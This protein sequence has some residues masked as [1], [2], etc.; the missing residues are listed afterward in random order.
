MFQP[1]QAAKAPSDDDEH[2]RDEVAVLLPERFQLVELFLLFEVEMSGH[3][4]V[5]EAPRGIAGVAGKRRI[6]R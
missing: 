2:P 3:G 1:F 6:M 5:P 4:G